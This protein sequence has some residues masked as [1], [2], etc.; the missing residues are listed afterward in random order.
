MAW[1][2]SKKSRSRCL[3][4]SSPSLWTDTAC[5]DIVIVTPNKFFADCGCPNFLVDAITMHSCSHCQLE[6]SH[7]CEQHPYEMVSKVLSATP[8][9]RPSILNVRHPRP[10][11]SLYL[12]H[13][14]QKV[15]CTRCDEKLCNPPH[16]HVVC[17]CVCVC[18]FVC[19]CVCACVC[20]RVCV[21]VL[22]VCII[23]HKLL[24]S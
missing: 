11:C 22:P 24:H 19:V 10:S 13:K 21:C 2:K 6:G 9:I 18:V 14:I 1:D 3:R 23:V 7:F 12:Y 8:M 5:V 4:T 20:V 15:C 17:V 16:I